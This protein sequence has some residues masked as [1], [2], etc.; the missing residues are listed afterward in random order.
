[1]QSMPSSMKYSTS[2]APPTLE[3]AR[4]PM[5]ESSRGLC[6]KRWNE[7]LG[8]YRYSHSKWLEVFPTRSMTSQKTIEMLRHVFARYG[9]PHQ[10]ISDNGPQFT[11]GEF[12]IFCQQNDIRHTLIPPYHLAS[13]GAVERAGRDSQASTVEGHIRQESIFQKGKNVAIKNYM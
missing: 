8:T 11:S 3:V 5:A 2:V 12:E 10:L 4:P 13:N 9:F 7:L 1:M 6:R